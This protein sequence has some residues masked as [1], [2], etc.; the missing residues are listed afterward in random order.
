MAKKRQMEVVRDTWKPLLESETLQTHSVAPAGKKSNS[1]TISYCK[2]LGG[3]DCNNDFS[4]EKWIHENKE[5][6]F[7]SV[8]YKVKVS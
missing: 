3:A 2:L 4:T 6:L 1:H 8:T 7:G 5:L